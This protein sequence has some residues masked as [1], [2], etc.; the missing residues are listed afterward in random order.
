MV[1]TRLA[2]LLPRLEDARTQ[3]GVVKAREILRLL[4][5]ADNRSFQE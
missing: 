3:I 2:A 4:S 5:A 1:Q